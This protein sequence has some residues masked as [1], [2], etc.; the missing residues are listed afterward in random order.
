MH[1][2]LRPCGPFRHSG[3]LRVPHIV[4]ALIRDSSGP[5]LGRTLEPWSGP[6]TAGRLL[7]VCLSASRAAAAAIGPPL[8]RAMSFDGSDGCEIEEEWLVPLGR[9]HMQCSTGLLRPVLLPGPAF[10]PVSTLRLPGRGE[11]ATGSPEGRVGKCK[12]PSAGCCRVSDGT[13]AALCLKA[14]GLED[15]SG[16][17]W[18]SIEEVTERA[19]GGDGDE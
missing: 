19:G 15:G 12:P 5:I 7:C 16:R 18:L 4:Q 9:F 8:A 13:M 10:K 6:G 17:N 14:G 2:L 11:D 1:R 3:L